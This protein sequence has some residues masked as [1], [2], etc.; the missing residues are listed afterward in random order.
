M[1]KA[2]NYFFAER[3]ILDAWQSS[4]YASELNQPKSHFPTLV[5][6]NEFVFYQIYRLESATLLKMIFFVR[7]SKGSSYIMSKFT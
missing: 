5:P 1:L 7:N 2:A 3:F 6:I 4:D